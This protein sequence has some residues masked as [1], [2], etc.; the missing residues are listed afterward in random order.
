MN[1]VHYVFIL[2]IGLF[3]SRSFILIFFNFFEPSSYLPQSAGIIDL[4]NIGV[5]KLIDSK[6]GRLSRGERASALMFGCLNPFSAARNITE[7]LTYKENRFLW[8]T[9]LEVKELDISIYLALSRAS[10]SDVHGRG[11]QCGEHPGS[12]VSP[13][14]IKPL[15][16]P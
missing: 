14:F 12:D 7:R 9:S 15:I 10:S 4:Y 2:D 3:I 5:W 8:L 16:L 1:S 13:L 11:Q 6:E